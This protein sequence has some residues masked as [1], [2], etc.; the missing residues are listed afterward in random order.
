MEAASACGAR[1]GRSVCAHV[2]SMSSASLAPC[3]MPWSKTFGFGAFGPASGQAAG[4]SPPAK[5]RPH[6]T[7]RELLLK[8]VT[9]SR[10]ALQLLMRVSCAPF[11]FE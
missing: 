6:C 8:S 11:I 3:E 5:P 9:L 7:L 1:R 2:V 4:A 10:A